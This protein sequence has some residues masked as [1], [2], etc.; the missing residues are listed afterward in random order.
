MAEWREKLSEMLKDIREEKREREERAEQEALAKARIE[1]EAVCERGAE[2]LRMHGIEVDRKEVEFLRRIS[3]HHLFSSSCWA[4]NY[5]FNVDLQL[6]SGRCVD[7]KVIKISDVGIYF[8][9]KEV[10]LRDPVLT[11]VVVRLAEMLE[12]VDLLEIE[13]QQEKARNE[14]AVAF[15]APSDSDVVVE[16]ENPIPPSDEIQESSTNAPKHDWFDMEGIQ[17]TLTGGLD[18]VQRLLDGVDRGEVIHDQLIPIM[19][20]LGALDLRISPTDAPYG[21]DLPF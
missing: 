7:V 19:L 12:E 5:Q 13:A 14:A 20:Q 11:S 4:G 15:F 10:T 17:R 16:P 8:G 9:E 21:D 3:D 18:F 1:A 6:G 2:L